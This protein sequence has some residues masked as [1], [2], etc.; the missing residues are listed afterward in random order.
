MPISLGG[1]EYFANDREQVR[2]HEGL[3]NDPVGAPLLDDWRKVQIADVC[4]VRYGDDGNRRKEPLDISDQRICFGSD[5][6]SKFVAVF[7]WHDPL[8]NKCAQDIPHTN[9]LDTLAVVT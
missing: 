9:T 4:A 1:I 3:G 6:K 8:G 5:L 2:L 7:S